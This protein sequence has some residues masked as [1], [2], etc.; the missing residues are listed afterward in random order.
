[1]RNWAAKV[2]NSSNSNSPEPAHF[3]VGTAHQP[4]TAI[5]THSQQEQQKPNIGNQQDRK[6]TRTVRRWRTNAELTV[7]VD[8]LDDALEGFV[9]DFQ[10]HDGE[11]GADRAGRDRALA[12]RIEAV[13]DFAQHCDAHA[14]QK[15]K[16]KQTT[17]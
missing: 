6:G 7:S 15:E 11:N 8:L 14:P 9:R 10:A 16:Q 12:R 3:G 4:T 17:K 13:E 1:M 2:Q 5:E